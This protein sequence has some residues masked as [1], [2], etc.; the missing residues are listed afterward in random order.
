[1]QEQTGSIAAVAAEETAGSRE[2]ADRPT[3]QIADN[4]P[5]IASNGKGKKMREEKNNAGS[6]I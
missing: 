2:A 6:S 1:M 3:K 4:Q 5:A